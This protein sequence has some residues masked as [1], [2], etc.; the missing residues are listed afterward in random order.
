[1]IAVIIPCYKVK[2]Q[3][4]EVLQTIPDFVDKIYVV[5]DCCPVGS[6]DYVT[7][8]NTD[9]R[10]QVFKNPVNL[11]VG[12]AVKTGYIQ[13]LKDG[14][15]IMVK[16]DGDGQMNPALIEKLIK[17]IRSGQADYVKGNRFFDIRTLLKMPRL[18]LFGNS[19]LSLV[20]KVVNGYWN[21]MDPTN[22]F[23]AIHRTSLAM[24]PLD[25]IENRYFFESDMLFRLGTVKAVVKDMAMD[26]HYADEV[27]NL[28]ISKVLFEFPPKY[29]SRFFKRIFYNY[30]LRD[31]NAAS[32]EMLLAFPLLIFG[33]IFG[34][35]HWYHSIALQ[36]AATTGTVML[37][38]LPIIV[39]FQ[40]MLSVLNY[41]IQ[42]IPS[43]PLVNK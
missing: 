36:K 40:L 14:C 6:G 39:G 43:E 1:M 4:L 16:L 20:N 32:V 13:A 37:A 10:V 8:H 21:L 18:R 27:S 11:G 34:S 42:N 19:V 30:F 9:A 17:P 24:L 28:S 26:A 33:V 2:T 31:F 15:E 3:I 38:V 7:E 23:T 35:Y 5:D 25:R 12:G 29:I 41:D 22:G